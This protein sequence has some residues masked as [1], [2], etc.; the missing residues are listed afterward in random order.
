MWALA[1]AFQSLLNGLQGTDDSNFDAACRRLVD[2]YDHW[3]ASLRPGAMDVLC[4]ALYQRIE[5]NYA[6]VEHLIDDML[7][8]DDRQQAPS[9]HKVWEVKASLELYVQS[10][11]KV[12]SDAAHS[13][14]ARLAAKNRALEEF[15]GKHSFEKSLGS[16]S[17]LSEFQHLQDF[18]TVCKQCRADGVADMG[19]PLRQAW[20]GHIRAFLHGIALVDL[21]VDTWKVVDD[22]VLLLKP[23]LPGDHQQWMR[24]LASLSEAL[25]ALLQLPSPPYS[26]STVSRIVEAPLA[27]PIHGPMWTERESKQ[28]HAYTFSIY[29]VIHII[30]HIYIYVYRCKKAQRSRSHEIAMVFFRVIWRPAGFSRLG[31]VAGLPCFFRETGR[32]HVVL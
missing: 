31:P 10:L 3:S 25:Q 1:Q 13:L 16:L 17:T 12:Q 21:P 27:G 5:K 23:I 7:Q 19:D 32:N 8:L 29:I 26:S 4:E 2:V 6:D 11:S 15:R 9:D 18:L 30:N 28:K 20:E 14:M 22:L 24:L